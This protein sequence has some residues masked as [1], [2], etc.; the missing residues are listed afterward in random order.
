MSGRKRVGAA[1]VAEV[2]RGATC[3]G[4]CQKAVVRVTDERVDMGRTLDPHARWIKIV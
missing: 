1:H 3:A 2:K 4:W